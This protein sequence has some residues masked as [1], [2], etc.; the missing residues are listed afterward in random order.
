VKKVVF[1]GMG[2]PA[3]NM[4]NVMEAI[5]LLGSEGGIGHK[6]LVFSTVGDPRIFERLLQGPVKPALALS[7]HTSR[8]D[9]RA[10]LLPKARA[11]TP[12]L[13]ELGEAYAR[14]TGYPIQYQWTLR[15]HQ[16]HAG[17]ARRHRPP[18]V[19]QVRD[20]EHDPLQHHPRPALPPPGLGEG[21]RHRPPAPPPRHPHQAAQLRRA[22]WG[23]RL[24]PAPRPQ[25]RHEA[26]I[27]VV[28]RPTG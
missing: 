4:D 20:H 23:R 14:A 25:H 16:R 1:M 12:E 13:V 10:E 22:G 7:L 17:G 27:R 15:R 24:R 6:N 28:K 8:A 11:S 21:R 19:G 9:L 26:P 3:H 2:E 5:Q 18:A